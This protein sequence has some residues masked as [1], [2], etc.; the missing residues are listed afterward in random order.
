V[1]LRDAAEN[2]VGSDDRLRVDDCNE[3]VV[4]GEVA[5]R[6]TRRMI[7][8]LMQRAVRDSLFPSL[9]V[10]MVVELGIGN[11]YYPGSHSLSSNL[12]KLGLQLAVDAA[13]NV[14]KE[15]APDLTHR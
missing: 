10:V 14:V 15:F 7:C 11:A 8:N 2:P 3:P 13:A 12:T 6:A 9:V 1:I 4:P 5:V